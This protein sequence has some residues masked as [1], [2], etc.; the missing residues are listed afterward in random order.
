[1]D[2]ALVANQPV[3]QHKL[4]G[5]HCLLD[6]SLDQLYNVEAVVVIS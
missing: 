3:L 5:G 6:E 4:A 2:E 1:M